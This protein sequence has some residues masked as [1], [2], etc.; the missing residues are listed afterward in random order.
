MACASYQEPEGRYWCVRVM[1]KGS[2]AVTTSIKAAIIDP[3][4]W[5]VWDEARAILEATRLPA[6]GT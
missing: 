6:A 1:A 3:E 4:E 5:K 2:T